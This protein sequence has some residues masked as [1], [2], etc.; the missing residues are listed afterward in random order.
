MMESERFIA[1]CSNMV[2]EVDLNIT[3]TEKE[4]EISDSIDKMVQDLLDSE[5]DKE[6]MLV[7]NKK[8]DLRREKKYSLRNKKKNNSPKV[9]C[10]PN[11]RRVKKER[12]QN[13]WFHNDR[14]HMELPRSGETGKV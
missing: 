9:R 1:S 8:E 13:Y 12:L 14:S 10:T 4:I 6:K 5:F 2:S 3:E 7:Y 11:K